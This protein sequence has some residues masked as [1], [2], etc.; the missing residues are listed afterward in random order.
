MRDAQLSTYLVYEMAAK[1]RLLIIV[2]KGQMP[3]HTTFDEAL[4]DRTRCSGDR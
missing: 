1:K 4:T 2:V 3:V